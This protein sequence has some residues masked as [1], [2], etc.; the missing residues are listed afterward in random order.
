[1][2][3]LRSS[4]GMDSEKSGMPS[5]QQ[6]ALGRVLTD[7]SEVVDGQ[8][9]APET[10]DPKRIDSQTA[11]VQSDAVGGD[12]GKEELAR[13]CVDRVSCLTPAQRALGD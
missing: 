11:G 8:T 7:D 1:M 9:T 5:K 10:T 4:G 6:L 12:G 3:P 13:R 2:E